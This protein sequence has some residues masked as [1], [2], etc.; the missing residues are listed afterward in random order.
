[1]LIEH[2]RFIYHRKVPL[3][4]QSTVGRKKWRARMGDDCDT[5]YVRLKAIKDDH[6]TLSARLKP[7]EER[8]DCRTAQRRA[9][10]VEAIAREAAKDAAYDK[11]CHANGVHTGI[12]QYVKEA[13]KVD[14]TA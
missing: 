8:R 1:M 10:E 13:G 2:G 11:R 7:P 4:F 6:D 12:E 3:E 5:A 9:R 14:E